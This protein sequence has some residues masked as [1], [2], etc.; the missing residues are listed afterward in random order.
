MRQIFQMRQS[1]MAYGKIAAA[2]NEKGILPPRWYWAVH[3]GNG[4]CKYSRLWA[5]ATVRS[6][7]NDDIYVGTLTQNCTGSRSY[8]DKTMIRKPELEWI[9]HEGA[10]EAIIGPELWEAVQKINQAA[11]QISANNTPPQASLFTGKLVCA[12]CGASIGKRYPFRKIVRFLSADS[13]RFL[14]VGK[15]PKPTAFPLNTYNTTQSNFAEVLREF[16]QKFFLISY[17]GKVSKMPNKSERKK[18]QTAKIITLS[19]LLFSYG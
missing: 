17:Y 13:G 12:D 16:F 8:K 5:Y 7:L 19:N 2:L 1:G 4:S 10:N 15:F 3:Y 18:L 9:S 14:L 11:K 6:L